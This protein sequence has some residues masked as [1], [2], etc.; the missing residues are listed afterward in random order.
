MNKMI[1]SESILKQI[2]E[3]SIYEVLKEEQYNEGF[4]HWLGNKYQSMRNAYN[5]FKNDFRAGQNDA[6]ERNKDY[7]PYKHYGD[8]E[9]DVRRMG[10]GA[11]PSYRY[12]LEKSRNQQARGEND[13]DEPITQSYNDD[14]KPQNKNTNPHPLLINQQE[15]NGSETNNTHPNNN[16]ITQGVNSKNITDYTQQDNR[17]EL[18]RVLRTLKQNG[19]EAVMKNGKIVNF[20]SIQGNKTPEQNTLIQQARRNPI[21][22]KNMYESEMKKLKK[23]LNELLESYNKISRK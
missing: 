18:N 23:Q 3:E 7:N 13:A 8:R 19:V 10:N 11:Y 17:I 20:K 4:G 5:N 21:V 14:V 12:D 15:T 2:V 6:R 16:N 9:N 1:I 22:V